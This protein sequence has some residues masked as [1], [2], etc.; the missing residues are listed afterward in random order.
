MV[1]TTNKLEAIL[2]CAFVLLLI[3]ACAD[4]YTELVHREERVEISFGGELENFTKYGGIR[5]NLL[6]EP[7]GDL[8]KKDS[9]IES[10]TYIISNAEI[11]SGTPLVFYKKWNRQTKCELNL[12]FSTFYVIEEDCDTKLMTVSVK[13]FSGTEELLDTVHTFRS[14]KKS[15]IPKGSPN[16]FILEK[17]SFIIKI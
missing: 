15:E 16:N 5:F 13:T 12:S 6:M 4:D 11:L 1:R 14:F 10:K 3:C 17:G 7:L 8:Y 9:L 2:L